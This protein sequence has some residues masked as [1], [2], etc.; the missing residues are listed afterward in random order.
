[1]ALDLTKSK[2]FD[3]VLEHPRDP[4]VKVYC[5][6]LTSEEEFAITEKLSPSV[7]PSNSYLGIGIS[8]EKEPKPTAI[9]QERFRKCVVNWEGIQ[10]D[11]KPL[12]CTDENKI[13]VANNHV[14]FA[15]WVFDRVK[16]EKLKQIQ[17]FN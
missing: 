2:E 13:W 10:R 11:G 12:E 16:Q 14:E 9:F 17:L 7:S 8:A 3:Y 4:E 1:M 15:G 6:G 5:H